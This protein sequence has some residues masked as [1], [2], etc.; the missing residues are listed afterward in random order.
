[1]LFPTI[2]KQITWVIAGIALGIIITVAF[3]AVVAF[4][5]VNGSSALAVTATPTKTPTKQVTATA[6]TTPSGTPTNPPTVPSTA[7][8]IP[9]PIKTS[10]NTPTPTSTAT[11]TLT[12]ELA[13]TFNP[14]KTTTISTE[15]T[16]TA[17][18]ELTHTLPLT[19]SEVIT[20]MGTP[21]PTPTPVPRTV[22]APIDIPNYAEIEDH[23]WFTRPFTDAYKTWGSYYYPYGTNGR[24]QYLWHHGIDIENPQ[25][26]TI[27]AVGA[28]T[29][30]HAGPDD[31]AL[32]GLVPNFYGQAVVIEHDQRWQDQPVYT[33]YGHV[34]KVLVQPG[35]RVEAGDPIAEVGQAGVAIGPHL[36]LEIRIGSAT[37]DDTRNPDLWIRPDPGHG[38]IAGRVVD[39]QGYYVPQQ[40][41]TLH[42]A[43]AP[44]RFWRETYTYPD[45]E[46]NADEGY[47]ETFTFSDVLA[48]NYLLKTFFDGRQLTVPV[49]VTNSVTSFV[50]LQQTQ[51]L[52][53]TP[54]LSPTPPIRLT[55]PSSQE[56][57]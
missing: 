8:P 21:T 18:F 57:K 38:V 23:F 25:G 36:N 10:T 22:M 48:G 29:V 39:Y 6:T 11:F 14:S 24:G 46:V 56:D 55:V 17:T 5:Q 30:N 1:M 26:T 20:P 52:L 37:Y 2:N 40:L 31:E 13:I 32:L 33:L 54:D 41:I 47:F 16:I 51:S 27:V 53:P 44:S 35:Q 34:S 45:N 3:V 15:P 12:P 4:K 9:L 50:L 43:E 7:T 49:A 42:R 28:G 19:T